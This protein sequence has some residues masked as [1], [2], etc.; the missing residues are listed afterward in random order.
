[1]DRTHKEFRTT[2]NSQF[3]LG[4]LTVG[5]ANMH[6]PISIVENPFSD[7]DLWGHQK[8]HY[9]IK[10]K[11]QMYYTNA[12]LEEIPEL[13]KFIWACDVFLRTS[14]LSG[15]HDDR[16]AYLT[17][18]TRS[19]KA[20]ETQRAPGWH[21]DCVQGDEVPVKQSG[22]IAFSWCDALPT[23]YAH[24][25]FDMRG[26]DIS[27]HNVFK[28]LDAQVK[29]ENIKTIDTHAITLMNTYCVHRAKVADVDCKRRYVRLSYT[30]VP[31]TNPR[32]HINPEIEYDY[33]VHSTTG[34]IPEHLI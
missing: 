24:Q 8:L 20:G 18:D 15:L 27:K 33:P 34:E 1:M 6:A 23:E 30:H 32:V 2:C 11:K 17:V 21:I 10:P 28:W 4:Y 9:L 29:P 22:N 19:V 3:D 12:L 5:Y 13:E 25:R 14:F 7:D 16:Y 31:I 26:C